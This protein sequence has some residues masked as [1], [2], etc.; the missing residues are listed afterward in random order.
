MEKMSATVFHGI[1]DIR[2][3][4]VKLPRAGG[5][6]AVIRVTPTIICDLFL[7]SIGQGEEELTVLSTVQARTSIRHTDPEGR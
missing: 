4:E 6:E 3:E 1:N 2:V 5:S 7:L